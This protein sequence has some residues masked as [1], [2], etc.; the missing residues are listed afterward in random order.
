MSVLKN[1]WVLAVLC[2]FLALVSYSAIIIKMI[3]G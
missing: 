2:A 3:N 1:K